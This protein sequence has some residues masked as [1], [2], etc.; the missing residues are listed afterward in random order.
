MIMTAEW[1]NNIIK[2]LSQYWWPVK[3]SFSITQ[4]L[5]V[6]EALI[7]KSYNLVASIDTTLSLKDQFSIDDVFIVKTVLEFIVYD[8]WIYEFTTCTWLDYYSQWIRYVEMFK[9]VLLYRDKDNFGWYDL[10]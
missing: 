3:L 9:H 1:K 7:K 6:N 2:I 10:I 8:L 4:Q 5:G